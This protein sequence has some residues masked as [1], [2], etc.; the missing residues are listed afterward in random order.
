MIV[1][2]DV[3]VIL[4]ALIKDSTTR[5]IILKTEQDFC[6]P[7]PSLHTIRKYGY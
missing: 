1:I 3:N 7:E 5:E 2:V 4:S 6:F